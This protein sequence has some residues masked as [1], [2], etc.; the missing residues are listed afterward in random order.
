MKMKMIILCEFLEINTLIE[1]FESNSP[2]IHKVSPLLKQLQNQL[3]KES[4]SGRVL[5]KPLIDQIYMD[6]EENMVSSA[7]EYWLN[8]RKEVYSS[9]K[10][11]LEQLLLGQPFFLS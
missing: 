1:I 5:P 9:L 4:S 7:I 8:F 10:M 2:Q 11:K 3:S 6:V